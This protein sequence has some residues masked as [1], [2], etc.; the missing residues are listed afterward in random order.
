MDIATD[1]TRSW[2]V[3]IYAAYLP[4]I[5]AHTGTSSAVDSEIAVY[6]YRQLWSLLEQP[7][8]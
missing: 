6:G 4:H 1:Q 3:L 5:Y 8:S 7:A 2:S